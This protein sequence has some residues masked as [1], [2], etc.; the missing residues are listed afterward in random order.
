MNTK[1]HLS[2]C[3]LCI[4]QLLTQKVVCLFFFLLPHCAALL[5]S[6]TAHSL[7]WT[8]QNRESVKAS[9]SRCQC[10]A[11]AIFLFYLFFCKSKN[12][13]GLWKAA[14]SAH[15]V[16]KFQ[17]Q[18]IFGTV[19]YLC[20][21]VVWAHQ[22]KPLIYF[23]A[24]ERSVYNCVCFFLF[25]ASALEQRIPRVGSGL[26]HQQPGRAAQPGQQTQ[27]DLHTRQQ[28]GP[29]QTVPLLSL[30]EEYPEANKGELCVCFLC[31]VWY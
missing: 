15:K 22:E 17:Q 25:C 31:D 13:C 23:A 2:F 30:Q 4:R 10:H 9:R 26:H 7:N 11:V 20:A 16:S 3:L 21:A 6:L 18:L 5:C 29:G 12:H 28:H 24:T 1:A 14:K 19:E 8:Q 27:R